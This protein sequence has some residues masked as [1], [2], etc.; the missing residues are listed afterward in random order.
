MDYHIDYKLLYKLAQC[1]FGHG[2]GSNSVRPPGWE[3]TAVT[4]AAAAA[5]A[6]A[7]ATTATT[8]APC[9]TIVNLLALP[10]VPHFLSLQKITTTPCCARQK[11]HG[12]F[13]AAAL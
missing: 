12:G 7:T 13:R 1:N 9:R 6:T 4:A 5:A 11:D 8:A 2:L 3:G 10:P